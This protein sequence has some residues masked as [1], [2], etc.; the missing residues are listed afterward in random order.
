M[1]ALDAQRSEVHEHEPSGWDAG[2]GEDKIR[3]LRV[4][5]GRH[6]DPHAVV[7]QVV[8]ILHIWRQRYQECYVHFTKILEKW[9]SKLTKF[10]FVAHS[11]C[12]LGVQTS[13][14]PAKAS[15]EIVRLPPLL[16]ESRL[17]AAVFGIVI[18]VTC[19]MCVLV[20]YY[21]DFSNLFFKAH[22]KSLFHIIL[23]NSDRI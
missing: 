4:G 19:M 2:V 7:E 9:K 8:D 14:K 3:E 18:K 11:H 17:L 22:V 6:L 21:P 13:A 20:F 10:R 5:H 16:A 15:L 1:P 23:E 12:V